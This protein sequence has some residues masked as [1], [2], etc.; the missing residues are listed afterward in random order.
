MLAP[1]SSIQGHHS[2][3]LEG[4]CDVEHRNGHRNRLAF[5]LSLAMGHSTWSSNGLNKRTNQRGRLWASGRSGKQGHR[6]CR[7]ICRGR[8]HCRECRYEVYKL[9]EPSSPLLVGDLY[10]DQQNSQGDT[11]VPRWLGAL[12]SPEACLTGRAVGTGAQLSCTDCNDPLLVFDD[13]TPR[14]RSGLSGPI[15]SISIADR[16]SVS[17]YAPRRGAAV[18]FVHSVGRSS[19]YDCLVWLLLRRFHKSF[20]ITFLYFSSIVHFRDKALR[21]KFDTI[22]TGTG[23]QSSL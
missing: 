12:L 15:R 23:Y 13:P 11:S 10:S 6:T 18:D 2:T 16:L 17:V 5:R 1:T 4:L 22:L 8:R 9:G 19:V 20:I 21:G 7:R 3:R 14:Q